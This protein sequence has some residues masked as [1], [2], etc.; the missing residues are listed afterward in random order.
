MIK[1]LILVHILVP[2]FRDEMF[3]M[4]PEGL[5]LHEE[6]IGANSPHSNLSSRGNVS[7]SDIQR[8]P[9]LRHLSPTV[10]HSPIM[11]FMENVDKTDSEEMKF[12]ETSMEMENEA[13]KRNQSQALDMSH[14]PDKE[15]R[16]SESN[17]DHEKAL[18]MQIKSNQSQALDM[19]CDPDM[20]TRNG[21][22]TKDDID[23]AR[24]VRDDGD[25]DNFSMAENIRKEFGM[26]TEDDDDDDDRR[27]QIEETAREI[28]LL[29]K[30]SNGSSPHS[31]RET[32]LDFSTNHEP[33]SHLLHTNSVAAPVSHSIT[34]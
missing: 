16:Y 15:M 11:K 8:S 33:Y 27:A 18:D 32:R 10:Q 25:V 1:I 21:Y 14:D 9:Q 3:V 22:F 4:K 30:A 17:R 12:G 13:L 28:E 34:S 19:S 7:P 2:C 20:R 6:V 29:R 31:L 5:G 24:E 26:S 23:N